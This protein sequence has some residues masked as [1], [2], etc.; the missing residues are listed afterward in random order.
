MPSFISKGGVWEPAQERVV[1][2]NAPKG[3]EI[4]EGPDRAALDML[5]AEGVTQLG[6]SF[7]LDPELQTRARQMGFK[8]VDE[9]LKVYGWDTKKAEE[10]YL[11]AKAV[12]VD[13]KD[14]RRKPSSVFPSGGDNT[15]PGADPKS[16]RKGGF[17]LPSDVPNAKL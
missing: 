6:T 7:R 16:H 8:D 1:D 5:K 2:P 9:Y 13:H 17:E 4:Y 11:A 3:K 14:P 15:A 12:V 10:A